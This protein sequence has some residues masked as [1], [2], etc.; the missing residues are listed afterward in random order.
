MSPCQFFAAPAG[1]VALQ[2][3]IMGVFNDH[4]IAAEAPAPL[5]AI[6]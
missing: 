5:N 6:Q 3:T 2:A 1:L 4:M